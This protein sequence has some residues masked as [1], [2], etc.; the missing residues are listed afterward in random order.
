[1]LINALR[2]RT[3]AVR[4]TAVIA[5]GKFGA[6]ASR[7]LP[8]L[9]E[10]QRDTDAEIRLIA[11]QVATSITTKLKEEDTNLSTWIEMLTAVGP[12]NRGQAADALRWMGPAAAKA[13]PILVKMTS[14]DPDEEV[15][16]SATRAGE[17]IA[18]PI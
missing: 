8:A 6:R 14:D 9:L 11:T 15:R 12:S 4:K 10:S 16:E 3:V 7:A 1:M 17:A 13:L 5:L 18:K 2:D